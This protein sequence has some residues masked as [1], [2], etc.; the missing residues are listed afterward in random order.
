MQCLKA[1]HHSLSTAELST[2]QHQDNMDPYER[3]FAL[4]D[5][6]YQV[7]LTQ[8]CVKR[9]GRSCHVVS[10]AVFNL[11]IGVDSVVC[12]LENLSCEKKATHTTTLKC[13]IE[14]TS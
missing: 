14:T 9:I 1:M 8:S 5:Q 3:L 2:S 11:Q 10:F 6:G 7:E 12:Y 4:E 13:N